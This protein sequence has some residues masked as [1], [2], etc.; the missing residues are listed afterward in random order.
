M[1]AN[2]LQSMH[3]VKQLLDTGNQEM[4]NRKRRNGNGNSARPDAIAVGFKV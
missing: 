1:P 3:G 2:I 4:G